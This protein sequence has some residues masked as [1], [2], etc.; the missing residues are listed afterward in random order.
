M[1]EIPRR[2]WKEK[3]R[4]KERSRVR[5]T[6]KKAREKEI[7][8]GDWDSYGRVSN[9]NIASNAS[10]ILRISFLHPFSVRRDSKLE[11]SW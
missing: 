1:N 5:E 3:K 10:P 6:W 8:V 4:G 11:L 9:L 2:D 7:R